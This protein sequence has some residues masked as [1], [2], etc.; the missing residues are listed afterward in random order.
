[1]GTFLFR[2]AMPG[3][4][5]LAEHH[6]Y[7]ALGAQLERFLAHDHASAFL[8]DM[9]RIGDARGTIE[10]GGSSGTTIASKEGRAKAR[11][12]D[13]RDGRE[14]PVSDLVGIDLNGSPVQ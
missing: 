8:A 2:T 5:L 7:L 12:C 6:Q 11:A 1:M 3:H 13:D 4:A 9:P 14:G 10:Q